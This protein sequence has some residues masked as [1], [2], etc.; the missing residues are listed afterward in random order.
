MSIGDDIKETY[1]EEGTP[2]IVY[3][4]GVTEPVQ[5]EKGLFE[6]Y[7]EQSTEFIRQFVSVVD[8]AYDT[9]IES[10]DIIVSKNIKY[11]VT[12]KDPYDVEGSCVYYRCML[13][14][15]NAQISIL[16]FNPER[17]YD[18]NYNPLPMYTVKL[19]NVPVLIEDDKRSTEAESTD[20]VYYASSSGYQAYIQKFDIS[21]GDRVVIENE[22]YLIENCHKYRID[23]CFVLMLKRVQDDT[24]TY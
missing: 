4:F 17:G 14:R 9:A 11:L 15:C 23:G 21:P 16:S 3:K 6:K 5:G 19:E 10:G 20:N 1:Q 7:T 12:S 18:E 2:Y 13:Y 22:T 8:V 24:E